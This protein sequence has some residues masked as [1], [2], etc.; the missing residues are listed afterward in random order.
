[1]PARKRLPPRIKAGRRSK[2][3]ATSRSVSSATSLA[4]LLRRPRRASRAF[5]RFVA[6]ALEELTAIPFA[7]ARSGDQHGRDFRSVRPAAVRI[8]GEAKFYRRTVSLR[9]RDL[10][11][12]I[13]EV[14]TSLP[15]L[16]LWILATTAPVSD[17]LEQTLRETLGKE[18]RSLLAL[19]FQD[20]TANRPSSLEL[21]MAGSQGALL[22]ELVPVSNLAA[23]RQILGRIRRR[24]G[25]RQGRELLRRSILDPVTGHGFW[26]QRTNEQF[27][28]YFRDATASI[29]NLGSDVAVGA[30]RANRARVKRIPIANAIA[31]WWRDWPGHHRPLVLVG[32]EGDGKSWCAADWL[33]EQID[34]SA[35][36]AAFFLTSDLCSSQSLPEVLANWSEN[37]F[38]GSPPHAWLQ[39]VDRW[40]LRNEPPT[41]VVILD[42]IN[43]RRSPEWWRSFF[44][45]MRATASE[46]DLTAEDAAEQAGGRVSST[47]T[48]FDQVAVIVTVRRGAWERY[49]DVWSVPNPVLIEVG[50][51]SEVELIEAL[52]TH[53]ISLNHLSPEMRLL[54]SKPRF[55]DLGVRL[56]ERIESSG[57]ISPA[58]LIL[59]EWKDRVGRK[60]S[61]TS[62]SDRD[63][64][65]LLRELAGRFRQGRLAPN[66]RELETLA[67]VPSAVFAAA[68]EELQTG[69]IFDEA[70]GRLTLRPDYLYCGLGLVLADEVS[71]AAVSGL[72]LAEVIA[73]HLAVEGLDQHASIVEAA[74]VAS[75]TKPRFP[76]P[77]QIAL[78]VA[79]SE[80]RNTGDAADDLL[81][82]YLP[83]DPSLWAEFAELLLTTDD[84][85][86]RLDRLSRGFRDSW[87]RS[88]VQ[89]ALRPALVRW[90]GLVCVGESTWAP[91]QESGYVADRFASVEAAR[92]RQG[93]NRGLAPTDNP[94]APALRT[95]A[96]SIISIR[97]PRDWLAPLADSVL[98]EELMGYPAHLDEIQWILRC[99]KVSCQ[100]EL[101]REVERL[102]G[103]E[104][105]IATAAAARLLWAE[106]SAVADFEVSAFQ[107]HEESIAEHRRDP[108]RSVYSWEREDWTRCCDRPDVAPLRRQRELVRFA[109]E[110]GVPVPPIALTEL[111]AAARGADPRGVWTTDSH[112]W[113]FD[114]LEVC[115]AAGSPEELAALVERVLTTLDERS[116]E[117]LRHVAFELPKR[118]LALIDE[119]RETVLRNAERLRSAEGV[120]D[121]LLFQ[122]A[123]LFGAVLP[124]LSS[125]EQLL[126]LLRLPSRRDLR[127]F[128]AS[129]RPPEDWALVADLLTRGLTSEA[130][131]RLLWYLSLNAESCPPSILELASAYWTHEESAVRAWALA[132]ARRALLRII[133]PIL[134]RWRP[135]ENTSTFENHFGSS[136]LAEA[137]RS[138]LTFEEIRQRSDRAYWSRAVELRGRRRNEL[139]A[140]TREVSRW[141][142]SAR[143]AT[144][145][146]S[147]NNPVGVSDLKVLSGFNDGLLVR[148][149]S[150]FV[151]MDIDKAEHWHFCANGFFEALS[152]VL[153]DNEP[154]LAIR[155]FDRLDRMRDGSTQ[156]VEG[157]QLL[158]HHRFCLRDSPAARAH[159]DRRAQKCKTDR[160][161]FDLV[162][163][164][165]NGN[166]ASW[167][168][169]TVA[170]GLASD[171]IW[172]KARALSLAAFRGCATH[173]F[174]LPEVAEL[175]G[176]I[177]EHATRSVQLWRR[178]QWGQH[179]FGRFAW[180]DEDRS[181]H[182]AWVL[183]LRCVD[184]RFGFWKDRP[185]SQLSFRRQAFLR[186]N[187]DDLQRHIKENEGKWDKRLFGEDI[188]KT[189]EPWL[190][191]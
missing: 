80:L 76:R 97:G 70:S 173:V 45:R 114:D 100:R 49:R 26:R 78:L 27:S 57:D 131:S 183:F 72:P 81:F 25:Y 120:T 149:A 161:L 132:L 123:M 104:H 58:R 162:R 2:V 171:V 14:V 63:F 19:S 11:G 87:E 129:F 20:G 16:D 21:L 112:D 163:V 74:F 91:Q 17:Q 187:N 108:C 29:A 185:V 116:G 32:G 152:R 59:E 102:R 67:P 150:E 145:H 111:A 109:H 68:A 89:D 43:E 182:A 148:W 166:A 24:R 117:D 103:L 62:F 142:D 167:L 53:G 136:L 165:E 105:P 128:E 130:L 12:E 56:R 73:E 69:G 90:L 168:E 189:V 15:D 13:A 147:A 41:A 23:V 138:S 127:R 170:E 61:L 99:S 190:D 51:F 46:D 5:E 157:I 60:R 180:E 144:V 153:A 139:S 85:P 125:S 179:W 96:L 50:P 141:L 158:D 94:N 47:T 44:D 126:G 30:V 159:W 6:T 188:A 135:T 124:W 95:L 181:A 121:D 186:N 191:A 164:A 83:S 34:G 177:G 184:R 151:A 40:L 31:C 160:D 75:L 143:D 93:E 110:P 118:A 7:L 55:F 22:E 154:E 38:R 64:Q 42:G 122:D 84:R 107:R 88:G 140:Y 156:T 176:W 133:R 113:Q 172:E 10:L 1:M 33:S 54:L 137:G 35:F 77:A 39:R 115:L 36:P 119:G 175:R 101:R 65:N 37:R 92:V 79:M 66:W 71:A 178:W 155:L 28:R 82:R 4:A 9:E 3:R 146:W 106:G 169:V 8:A 174:K 18:G 52:A 86:E 134:E 48:W 98:A